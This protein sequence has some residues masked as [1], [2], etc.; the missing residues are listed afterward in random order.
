MIIKR[1]CLSVFLSQKSSKWRYFKSNRDAHSFRGTTFTSCTR[2]HDPDDQA[3]C[4]T[5]VSFYQIWLK[6]SFYKFN[7]Y[8]WGRGYRVIICLLFCW[9]V[10]C[11]SLFT[12]SIS[13]SKWPNFYRTQVSAYRSH[14]F[15]SVYFAIFLAVFFALHKK[16]RKYLR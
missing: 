9:V 10:C 16:Y 7:K 6:H 3:W 1:I 4:S 11:I 5:K 13:T 8:V 15:F 12:H 14:R 2:E